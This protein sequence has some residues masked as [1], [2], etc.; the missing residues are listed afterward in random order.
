MLRELVSSV[1]ALVWD[2]ILVVN[3]NE[4]VKKPMSPAFTWG[5]DTIKE[6]EE[7]I[8]VSNFRSNKHTMMLVLS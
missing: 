8:P 4:K 1:T 3:G 5:L 2:A 6:K 7:N